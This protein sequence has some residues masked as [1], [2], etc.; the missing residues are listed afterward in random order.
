MLSLLFFITQIGGSS[1]YL[2]F[3][4]RRH[5]FSVG[6]R[7]LHAGVEAGPVVGLDDLATDHLIGANATVIGTLGTREAVL[8]PTER[9][10]VEV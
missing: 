7:D 1:V 10:A 3:P 4:L 5:H 2:E 6:S 8:G 9:P